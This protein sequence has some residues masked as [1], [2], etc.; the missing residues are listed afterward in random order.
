MQ[1]TVIF[2]SAPGPKE[3]C[4]PP[5]LRSPAVQAAALSGFSQSPRQQLFLIGRG[6]G[7]RRSARPQA[8]SEGN[9]ARVQRIDR[10]YDCLCLLHASELASLAIPRPSDIA[11]E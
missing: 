1:R 7:G 5:S 9:S 2:N 3:A 8:L 10:G 4:L 11:A 6:K